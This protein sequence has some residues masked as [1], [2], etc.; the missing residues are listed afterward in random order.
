MTLL[1]YLERRKTPVSTAE[2]CRIFKRSDNWVT[3]H[4]KRLV[5]QGFV[6]SEKRMQQSSISGKKSMA[7][8]YNAVNKR[9]KVGQKRHKVEYHNPFAI[10]Q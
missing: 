3:K 4:A 1:D 9:L 5:E 10:R 6:T 8:F 2:L 7:N